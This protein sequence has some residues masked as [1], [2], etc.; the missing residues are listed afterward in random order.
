[1]NKKVTIHFDDPR[2]MASQII[3]TQ[4]QDENESIYEWII[5]YMT[6]EEELA[7]CPVEWDLGFKIQEVVDEIH[8]RR[9]RPVTDYVPTPFLDVYSFSATYDEI[10][11]TYLVRC[12]HLGTSRSMYA[13][14]DKEKKRV[15]LS[16]NK[17]LFHRVVDTIER[18]LTLR[19]IWNQNKGHFLQMPLTIDDDEIYAMWYDDTNWRFNILVRDHVNVDEVYPV[20]ALYD[21]STERFVI[22]VKGDHPWGNQAAE[23]LEKRLNEIDIYNTA[24]DPSDY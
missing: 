2:E 6:L 9:H 19:H 10:F 15:V 21:Y 4:A 3:E 8:L 14:Y 5:G 12:N 16:D 18:V 1:L 11:D 22:T 23:D 13:E 20:V 17:Q 7:G 24:Y